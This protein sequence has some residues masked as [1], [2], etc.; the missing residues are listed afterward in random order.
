M[1]RWILVFPVVL[2]LSSCAP[3]K[4]AEERKGPPIEQPAIPTAENKANP[5]AKYIEVAG[6]RMSEKSPTKLAVKFV[7]INHSE[8]EVAD[9]GLDVTTQ[10]CTVS[11]KVPPL[12]P[13]EMKEVTGECPTKL[14][15][16]ELP[17]WQFIRPSFKITSP[18]DK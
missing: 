5:L 3:E 7:V 10:P 17:D 1:S 15:V 11:V 4:K 13:E 6:F 16:Y 14:R 12:G 8:A 18:A 9:L 2:A